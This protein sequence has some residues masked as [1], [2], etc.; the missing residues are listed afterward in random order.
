MRDHSHAI[1]PAIL[2]SLTLALLTPN[3]A[4]AYV[5]PGPG[6]ELIPYFYSLMV[7]VGLALVATMCW[8]VQALLRRIRGGARRRANKS[9]QESFNESQSAAVAAGH[10]PA[11]R[12]T[13]V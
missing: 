12:E 5:G 13:L 6:L 2:L 9:S 8:P 11:D 10:S 7:W 1:V 3:H 4:L